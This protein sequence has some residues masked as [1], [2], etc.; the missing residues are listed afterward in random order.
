MFAQMCFG[1]ILMTRG[2]PLALL[3]VVV[4]ILGFI[5]CGMATTEE[6]KDA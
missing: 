5:S 2:Q 3:S 4:G 6:K 1:I